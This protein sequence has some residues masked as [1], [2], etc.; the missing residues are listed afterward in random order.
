MENPNPYWITFY[1]SNLEATLVPH[2]D[3]VVIT[4][5]VNN[6]G[7]SRFLVDKGSALS[8]LYLNC[9]IEMELPDKFIIKD[10]GE[11]TR[12][13]GSTLNTIVSYAQHQ[14]AW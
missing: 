12:F 6:W 1:E 10:I 2:S 7:I 4:T 8:L 9:W 13:N 11:M 3:L 5:L 14:V